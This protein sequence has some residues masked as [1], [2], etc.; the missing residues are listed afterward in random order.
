[1]KS[2]KDHIISIIKEFLQ[3]NTKLSDAYNR[4]DLKLYW[5]DIMPEDTLEYTKNIS[6]R[7][8]VLTIKIESAPL[9]QNL[10]YRAEELKNELN[11]KTKTS[12]I[13]R[14]VFR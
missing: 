7:A 3:E 10:I 12:Q 6:F 1:M 4:E 9:R 14:L 11:K 2:D 8:G 5:K 13:D